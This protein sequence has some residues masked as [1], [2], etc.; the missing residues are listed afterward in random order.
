M[1]VSLSH[2]LAAEGDLSVGLHVAAKIDLIGLGTTSTTTSSTTT[3]STTTTTTTTITTT[4]SAYLY[5][6]LLPGTMNDPKHLTLMDRS[7]CLE[8]QTE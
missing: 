3:S 5:L 1:L 6:P 8:G 2:M 4:T 7:R